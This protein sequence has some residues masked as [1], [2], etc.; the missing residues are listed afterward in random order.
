M[1][2]NMNKTIVVI[3]LVGILLTGCGKQEKNTLKIADQYG[4]AYAP[5][6]IMKEK[7]MLEEILPNVEIQWEKLANTAAIREAVLSDNLDVGFMGIPP[8]LIS[9]EQEMPWKMMIGLSISPLGLVTNDSEVN[10]LKDLFDNGKIALPQ[11]G[12]IQHILLAMAAEREMGQADIFDNQLIT[13]NHPDGYQAL[14]AGTEVKA[15]FTSPPYLFQEMDVEGQKLVISGKEAM[16]Q[17][18]TFIVGV[19]T[20]DFHDKSKH[21]EAVNEAIARAINFIETERDETVEILAN[22][23]GL[24]VSVVEDYLYNRG[25]KYSTDILGVEKFVDFMM[26]NGYLTK[27]ID[28][29]DLKFK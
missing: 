10:E 3:L 21:Y 29:D 2:Y 20:E 26:R 16:G 17:E 19:C 1:M 13:M 25:M 18:F 9:Y 4:L 5:I 14:L 28:I 6:Q 24:E 12:S 15:H 11:P 27:E 8:F 7:G 22:V 23:Y